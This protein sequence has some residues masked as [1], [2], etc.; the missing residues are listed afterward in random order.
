MPITAAGLKVLASMRK[1]SSDP[2][3]G[4]S[5]FYASINKGIPGSDKWE[6]NPAPDA[7]MGEHIAQIHTHM[8]NIGHSLGAIAD[9]VNLL[10]RIR[11]KAGL[12]DARTA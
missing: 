6:G 1:G 10:K 8:E 7:P 12:P 4:K 3:A 9:K 11:E 5:E 2:K